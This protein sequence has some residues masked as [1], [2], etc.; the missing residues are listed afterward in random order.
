V[1]KTLD[2]KGNLDIGGGKGAAGPLLLGLSCGNSVSKTQDI[3]FNAANTSHVTN[4][5]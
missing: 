2:L 5:K 1:H 3:G 4:L